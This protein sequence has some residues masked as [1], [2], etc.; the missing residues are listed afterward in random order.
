MLPS[1]PQHAKP[2][3]DC[4]LYPL[5][6]ASRCT[7]SRLATR[8]LCHRP[9]TGLFQTDV[10]TVRPCQSTSRGS[11][12]FTRALSSAHALPSA[13]PSRPPIMA[14]H[15]QPRAEGLTFLR[16]GADPEHVSVQIL[17][18]H[19]VGPAEVRG[20]LPDPGALPVILLEERLDVGD[21]DPYPRAGLT[22][23]AFGEEDAAAIARDRGDDPGVL[24]IEREPED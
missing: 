4:R 15:I 9:S 20:R 5:T 18:L 7:R 1:A 14:V 13:L 21:A 8:V 24:P 16:V 19:F 2:E 12:T 10:R 23:I 17:D 3:D 6:S 22:L 11:L